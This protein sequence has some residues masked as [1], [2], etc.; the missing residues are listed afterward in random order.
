MLCVYSAV[1]RVSIDRKEL[2]N[3]VDFEDLKKSP[4]S[5]NQKYSFLYLFACAEKKIQLLCFNLLLQDYFNVSCLL[6]NSHHLNDTSRIR[7]TR[8]LFTND[9]KCFEGVTE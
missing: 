7:I 5:S 9:K 1:Q 6:K 2:L 8:A 3:T 4:R